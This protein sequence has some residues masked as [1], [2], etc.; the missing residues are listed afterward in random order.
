MGNDA[1]ATTACRRCRE[2]KV[3]ECLCPQIT[4]KSDTMQLRCSRE[5]PRCA[6]CI[7]LDAQC[8]YPPPPDRKQLAAARVTKRKRATDHEQH[9]DN[10][11]HEPGGH[12]SPRQDAARRRSAVQLP[13]RGVQRDLLDVYFSYTFNSTLMFDRTSVSRAWADDQLSEPVLL[14]ICAMA[15]VYARLSVLEGRLADRVQGFCILPPS[16]SSRT[17]QY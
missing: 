7:R 11:T 9:P 5:L 4:N 15:T 3:N 12:P 2:Q 13:P 6:R 8:G 1:E 16:R 17:G 10:S 14:A